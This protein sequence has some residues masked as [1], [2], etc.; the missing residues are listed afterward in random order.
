MTRSVDVLPRTPRAHVMDSSK[1]HAVALSDLGDRLSRRRPYG[2]HVV[3]CERRNIA[4][5]DV[6]RLRHELKV[7]RID[8]RS[9][10]AKVINLE[11]VGDATEGLFIHGPMSQESLPGEPHSSVSIGRNFTKPDP[12]GCR[13]VPIFFDPHGTRYFVLHVEITYVSH[14]EAHRLASYVTEPDICLPSNRSQPATAT[15]TDPTWVRSRI[16]RRRPCRPV[17]SNKGSLIASLSFAARSRVYPGILPAPAS[18]IHGQM[19]TQ[20]GVPFQTR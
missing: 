16:C 15:L 3:G 12:A 5:L 8:A 19:L 10:S 11:I 17:P 6:Y 1:S 13:V 14:D 4:A 9:L 7:R 20:G 18:A 2:T